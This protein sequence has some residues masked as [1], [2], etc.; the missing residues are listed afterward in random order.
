MKVRDFK[1]LIII[2][3][4]TEESS[5]TKLDVFLARML[6]KILRCTHSLSHLFASQFISISL[7]YQKI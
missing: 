4:L 5:I 2:L 3:N 6:C 1:K 7:I